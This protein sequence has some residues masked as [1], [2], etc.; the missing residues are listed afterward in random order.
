MN[1][2][3]LLNLNAKMGIIL[4]EKSILKGDYLLVYNINYVIFKY[5]MY[6]IIFCQYLHLID[7]K[8][9]MLKYSNN[10]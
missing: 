1:M 4:Y 3:N 2:F 9:L 10:F 5:I 8:I 6:I 7:K